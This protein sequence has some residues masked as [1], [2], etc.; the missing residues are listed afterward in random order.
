MSKVAVVRVEDTPVSVHEAFEL[1]GG[2]SLCVKEASS[3]LV[4]PNACLAIEKPGVMT[5]CEVVQAVVKEVKALEAEPVVGESAIHGTSTKE[6]LEKSGIAEMCRK[7]N[8]QLIDFDLCERKGVTIQYGDKT[9]STYVARPV[10]ECDAV[11]SVPVMKT[12]AQTGVTLSLKNMKGCFPGDEKKKFHR[13]HLDKAIAGINA[14]IKPCYA[15]I[16]GRVAME[17][18]G[19]IA[20]EPVDMNVLVCSPDLVAA[21][22]V[23]RILMGFSREEVSH[24]ELASNLGL[25]VSDIHSIEVVGEPLKSVMREFKKPWIEAASFENITVVDGDACSGCVTECMN[26]L[27]QNKEKLMSLGSVTVVLG[28]KGVKNLKD[29]GG[30]VLAFGNCVK[31]LDTDF[32]VEG[33]PPLGYEIGNVLQV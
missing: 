11:I 5:T 29:T 31:N 12:H 16:D 25:G 15:V 7:E 6:A 30:K 32:I 3:V 24:I 4:K 23:A 10:L 17:G 18:L 9:L 2:L 14:L 13:W 1:A 22:T 21:D 33:C 26:Y 27:L 8:V 19:P 20:G 28:P